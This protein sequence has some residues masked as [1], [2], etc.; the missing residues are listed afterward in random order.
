MNELFYRLNNGKALSSF[1][2]MRAKI[3]CHNK[4]KDLSN[5]EI[6]TSV[7]T[8]KALAANKAEE[9]AMK[10]WATLYMTFP[11]YERK[12][13]EPEITIA[14]ITDEQVF[15]IKDAFIRLQNV[16]KLMK[17]YQTADYAR[18]AKRMMVK[19]HFLSLIPLTLR[20]KKDG[21]LVED[22]MEWVQKFFSG[23]KYASISEAYN[24]ASGNGS[25]KSDNIKIR[26]NEM[27]ADYEKYFKNKIKNEP[28]IDLT[29]EAEAV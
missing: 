8:E 15:T 1:D 22:F 7:L 18:S 3:K 17:E 25:A 2:S 13:L 27:T 4:I 23:K 16:Y 21:I 26:L 24:R 29:I 14:D 5:H 11:S 10:A 6:F 28:I 9:L 12:E 19:T 20:S